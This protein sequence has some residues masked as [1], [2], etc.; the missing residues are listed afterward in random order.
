MSAESPQGARV[1]GARWLDR[2]GVDP[3]LV[4]NS[5]GAGPLE[6]FRRSGSPNAAVAKEVEGDATRRDLAITSPAV[7]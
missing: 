3:G 6:R 5:A 1:A 7:E 4:T 2:V